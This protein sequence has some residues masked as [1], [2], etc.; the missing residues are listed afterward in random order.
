[1]Y[2]YIY[3]E[4]RNN[5]TQYKLI[6]FGLNLFEFVLTL[7]KMT[8]GLLFY[9]IIFNK[10]VYCLVKGLNALCIYKNKCSY[11]N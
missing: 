3:C 10:I 5:T 7:F 2:I 1:M 6:C 8:Y 11:P 4:N 9:V